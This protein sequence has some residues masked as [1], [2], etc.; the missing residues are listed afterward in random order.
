MIPAGLRIFVCTEPVDM[1]CGFDRLAA[2]ARSRIGEDPQQGAMLVVFSNRG[3]NRLKVLWFDRNGY[4][5]LYKRF[6]GALA[7]LP[8]ASGSGSLR[9]DSGALAKLIAG[10]DRERH[11]AQR[12]ANKKARCIDLHTEREIVAQRAAH[13][14]N[15]GA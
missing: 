11:N 1:R 10:V 5:L 9:I 14:A 4:C 13:L 8:A 7:Q 2:A 3:A 6:H 12:G 15:C